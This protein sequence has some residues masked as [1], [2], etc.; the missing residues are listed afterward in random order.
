MF[1]CI[2]ELEDIL[3]T[4]KSFPWVVSGYYIATRGADEA[5]RD[6]APAEFL[7]GRSMCKIFRSQAPAAY[8]A[9]TRAVRLGGYATS[10]RLEAAFWQMLEEIAEHEGMT[11]NRFV[12]TVHDEILDEQGEVRNF[13][14]L[15]RVICLQWSQ[16]AHA[17]A[18]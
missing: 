13:A 2:G 5:I 15:L 1:L 14:S 17:P 16:R 11:L 8:A 4:R 3:T 10:I 6:G 12:S 9:E 18:V 7:R